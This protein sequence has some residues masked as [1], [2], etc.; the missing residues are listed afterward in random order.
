M[1]SEPNDAAYGDT[2]L[3]LFL[4]NQFKVLLLQ[5]ESRMCACAQRTGASHSGEI[6]WREHVAHVPRS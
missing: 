1:R 3:K 2:V 6:T 5:N 4:K